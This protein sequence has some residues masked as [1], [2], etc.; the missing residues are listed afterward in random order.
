MTGAQYVHHSPYA[1]SDVSHPLVKAVTAPHVVQQ[2]LLLNPAQHLVQQPTSIQPFATPQPQQQVVPN[3][4]MPQGQTT[5]VA[6]F[7]SGQPPVR[8]AASVSESEAES[9]SSS[10]SAG[11]TPP[12]GPV[13]TQICSCGCGQPIFSHSQQLV[14]QQ[15][16]A[17]TSPQQIQPIQQMQ[18]SVVQQPQQPVV[19]QPQQPIIQQQQPAIHQQQQ[20]QQ[21]PVIQQQ[22]Q[23][24]MRAAIQQPQQMRQPVTGAII[25]L[26]MVQQ[27]QQ[28]LQQTYV[29]QQPQTLTP[30]QCPTVLP[31]MSPVSSPPSPTT[32]F[33]TVKPVLKKIAK[34]GRSTP[35]VTDLRLIVRFK[36]GREGAYSCEV[37]MSNGTHVIVRGDWGQDLGVIVGNGGPE[38]NEPSP[39]KR[40]WVARTATDEE[41]SDWKQLL[42]AEESA[43]QY[44][45]Q[46]AEN[47]N[48]VIDFHRA[49]YQLDGSKL[50]FHYTTTI[51]H[52]DFRDILR[53]GYREFR[54]RIW[55]NNCVPKKGE[56][57]D[58][59][60]LTCGPIPVSK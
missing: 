14:Q 46:Q 55:L 12:M 30:F 26:P 36:H 60:D 38:P 10:F 41:I 16:P 9:T 47:H 32:V 1:V 53:D 57:G 44:I 51:G 3:Y 56:K 23:Q 31:V 59:L 20:Q 25:Q 37:M 35:P 52:P 40:S 11:S 18:Q 48:V 45:R 4:S 54:C 29:P 19:Q 28:P 15:L 5:T 24:Q 13:Q 17:N 34:S 7:Y 2:P 42:I 6:Q 27:P 50:T 21:Q 22:Q 8:L 39:R 33:T 43:L 49:E 58:T